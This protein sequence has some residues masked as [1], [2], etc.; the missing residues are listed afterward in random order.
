MVF[1]YLLVYAEAT[2]QKEE[3]PEIPTF[4]IAQERDG[5]YLGKHFFKR[6]EIKIHQ[7]NYLNKLN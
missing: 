3:K 4:S 6:R 5:K 1:N 2:A 7:N